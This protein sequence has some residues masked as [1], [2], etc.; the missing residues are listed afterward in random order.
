MISVDVTVV[1]GGIIGCAVADK[2]S[3]A[4]FKPLLLERESQLATGVTSRNSEVIHGGMYYPTDSLKAKCCVD[5]R[6][7]LVQFCIENKIGYKKCGKLIV[8][9]DQ[10]D[11][12]GIESLFNQG[13]DNDVEN[14]VLLDQNHLNKLEPEVSAIAALYSPETGII[15]AEGAAKALAHRAAENGAEIMCDSNVEAIEHNGN[16]QV[17]VSRGSEKWTHKSRIVINCAGLD[18]DSLVDSDVKQ[19]F[20]KGNYFSVNNGHFGKISRLIYPVPPTGKDTLGIHLCIDMAGCMRLGPDYEQFDGDLDYTVDPNRADS[21]YEGASKFLPFLKRKDL[22]PAFAGIRPKIDTD[23][24]FA[25]FHIENRD[26]LINLIG[27]DSPGLT[28]AMSIADIVTQK[29]QEQ[30]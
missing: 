26:G 28:S 4:G 5:G 12:P 20:V 16:W 8:A 17:T 21:F 1:G 27:I 2:L 22:T 13:S 24:P 15:D 30:S 9:V 11:L 25:D 18:A 14:L 23:K 7:Q 10:S 29:V 6:R 19:K 3:A